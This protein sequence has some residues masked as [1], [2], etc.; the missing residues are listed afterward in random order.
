MA[1]SRIMVHEY[2][3][4][5]MIYLNILST[6]CFIVLRVIYY[7]FRSSL[8]GIFRTRIIFHPLLIGIIVINLNTYTYAQDDATCL[9]KKNLPNYA[10]SSKEQLR[11]KLAAKQ[12][13]SARDYGLPPLIKLPLGKHEFIK[14]V[15][16]PPGKFNMGC[17]IPLIRLIEIF[18][19][20]YMFKGLSPKQHIEGGGLDPWKDQY[21][22]HH[23]EITHGYYMSL[24]EITY[25]QLNAVMKLGELAARGIDIDLNNIKKP[26]KHISWKD[27]Q[28]FIKYVNQRIKNDSIS[29]RLPTEAEWEYACRAGT[30][31]LYSFGDDPSDLNKY[32]W[33]VENTV[34]KG[35]KYPRDVG[36]KKPNSWSLYDMH[37]NVAEWCSD[38]YDKDY[39]NNSPVKD[40]KGPNNGKERVYRGGSFNDIAY[41]L[42][43]ANRSRGSLINYVGF[44][45]VLKPILQNS[46]LNSK[47]HK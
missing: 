1:L 41:F 27:T 33:Y 44:R 8:I 46:P 45:V 42:R 11:F 34:K 26:A 21:P 2:Y 4:M 18:Q 25:G 22:S 32:A 40:P 16:V 19:K 3:M 28:L 31:S 38:W 9:F 24:Y 47:D 29:I 35:G 20:S 17:N 23:V 12:A 37:G 7:I 39:Y 14:M 6:F 36:N 15:W 43:S 30:T 5:I 13:E 10:M